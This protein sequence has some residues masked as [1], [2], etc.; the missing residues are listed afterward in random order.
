MNEKRVLMI[1]DDEKLRSAYQS[2]LQDEGYTV[3]IATTGNQALDK[4]EKTEFHLV[5]L[6]V[7][8]PD[9]MG[10][11]VAKGIRARDEKVPIIMITGY[12]TIQES[13]D[14]LEFGIHEIL[15]KP[16]G[17]SELLRTAQDALS[18]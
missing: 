5:I 15:I 18:P 14:A 1:E 13:I 8:L 10:D 12:P 7:K 9:I 16:V 4:A 3:E 6:D 2:I 17:I 11:D